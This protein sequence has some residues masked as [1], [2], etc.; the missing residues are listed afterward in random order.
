MSGGHGNGGG[1]EGIVD[2]IIENLQPSKIKKNVLKPHRKAR[3][4]YSVKDDSVSDYAGFTKQIR[5]YVKHHHKE[6]FKAGLDDDRALGIAVEAIDRAYR[7]EGGMTGAFKAAKDGDLQEVLD[8]IAGYFMSQS[9]THYTNA[10][11]HR[12]DPTNFE[13]HVKVA[14]A[15]QGKYGH[16]MPKSHQNKKAAELAPDYS[17]LIKHHVKK[18]TETANVY[19]T[20][21]KGG[22]KAH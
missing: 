1:I 22:H 20:E 19:G 21:K 8:N 3:R 16:L 10:Q 17:E 12:I 7:E 14:E 2:D 15:L 9:Q 13:D 5:D 4:G 6:V 11:I 18:V